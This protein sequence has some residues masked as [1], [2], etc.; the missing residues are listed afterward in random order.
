M[1][2]LENTL[3]L[4]LLKMA[5]SRES[6]PLNL[7]FGSA[8]AFSISNPPQIPE[9]RGKGVLSAKLFSVAVMRLERCIFSIERLT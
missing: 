6:S 4:L 9:K 5:S 8:I 2:L 3:V 1:V 7:G